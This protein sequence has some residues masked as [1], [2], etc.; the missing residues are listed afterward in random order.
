MHDGKDAHT[1]QTTDGPL[2]MVEI[3]GVFFRCYSTF[4]GTF[5]DY[6]EFRTGITRT[7]VKRI[8]VV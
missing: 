7:N 5:G 8:I 1:R 2:R 3:S 4:A 6:Y